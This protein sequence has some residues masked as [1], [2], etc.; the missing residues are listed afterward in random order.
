MI[1]PEENEVINAEAAFFEATEAI[2]SAMK[3]R[4]WS[5]HDSW[6]HLEGLLGQAEVGPE[7]RGTAKVQFDMIWPEGS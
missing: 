2:V 3:A 6:R 5:R 4:G 7:E 1:R